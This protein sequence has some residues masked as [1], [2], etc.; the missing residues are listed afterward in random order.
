MTCNSF[1]K[2]K[3]RQLC[4][5]EIFSGLMEPSSCYPC[6]LKPKAID[7]AEN[8][9]CSAFSACCVRF[10]PHF[11]LLSCRQ[12]RMLVS[13]GQVH[14]HAWFNSDILYDTKGEDYSAGLS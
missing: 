10:D 1:S 11:E 12:K 3:R 5:S 6:H 7:V 14:I 4:S 2:L 13:V 9:Y 8:C